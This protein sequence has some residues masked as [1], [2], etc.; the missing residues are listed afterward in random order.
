M[1][2]TIKEGDF[3]E[4][5]YTGKT[6]EGQIFDTTLEKVAKENNLL[7]EGMKFDPVTICVGQKQLLPGLD[8]QLE[9][10]EV[11]KDYT[12]ELSAEKAFGKRD[13]KK[14]KIVPARVF[15]E[16]KL[17]PQPGLQIDVDGQ[18]GTVIR[19]SGGRV[20]VNFNHPIAGKNVIYEIRV[21]R[22]VT[23]PSEQIAH[24]LN[25]TFKI[26]QEQIKVELKE[27][28]AT[29]T[30]PVTMPDPFIHEISKKLAELTKL[31]EVKF[32]V[33]KEEKKE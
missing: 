28:K 30:M 23:D 14:I 5:D 31:K 20:L 22:K 15:R 11:D 33:K 3:I 16:H 6:K 29:I 19:E 17:E 10:K 21:V 7:N 12:I 13:V 4:L 32:V 2:E 1:T 25:T 24:F 9:G 18:I 26:P 27:E 8:E